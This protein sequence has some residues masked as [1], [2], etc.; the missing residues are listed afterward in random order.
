MKFADLKTR[1]IEAEAFQA[2]TQG[3][4]S[5]A[6]LRELEAGFTGLKQRVIR[7]TTARIKN[8]EGTLANLKRRIE[9]AQDHWSDLQMRTDGM[10]PAIVLP[11]IVLFLALL[12][13]AGEG[14]FLAPV[15]DALGI[16]DPSVQLV[17]AGVIVVVTSG[18]V[19][20]TKRQL[21]SHT[22]PATGSNMPEETVRQGRVA[23]Y[24][25]IVLL[26][27]LSILSLTLVFFLGLWRAEQM[28]FSA[29]LQQAGAWKKFMAGNPELTRAVVV[30]LTTGLPVFVAVVFDWALSGLGLAWEWRKSRHQC[31]WFAKQLDQTEKKLEAEKEARASRLAELDEKCKEWKNS[32]EHHH[33]LGKQIGAWKTPL[34]RVILKIAAVLFLI[35]AMC[36]LLNQFVSGYIISDSAR[37]FIYA[38]LTLGLGGLYAAHAIRAWDRPTAKQ[39]FKQ[40]ATIWREAK[41][42]TTNAQPDEKERKASPTLIG[43]KPEDVNGKRLSS[44]TSDVAAQAR[45]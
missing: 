12:V 24:L 27:L 8:L 1:Y 26:V 39:L 5:E 6:Q 44:P 16:A 28:I 32:Y 30:L 4:V 9:E 18:L 11:L 14:F 21:L 42:P 43:E 13:V 29:S 7:D 38:L 3:V 35:A 33:A 15:M 2:G 19:E 23:R 25:K 36:F 31:H 20:I 10:P 45:P 41:S 22:K 17:F 34:W 40:R 37:L